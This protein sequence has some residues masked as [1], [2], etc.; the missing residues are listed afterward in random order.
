[1]SG[2]RLVRLLAEASRSAR[3]GGSAEDVL[4]ALAPAIEGALGAT[5]SLDEGRLSLR[6]G[7]AVLVLEAD[8]PP[9][10]S[11]AFDEDEI[12]AGAALAQ[13]LAAVGDREALFLQVLRSN[14]WLARLDDLSRGIVAR[15]DVAEIVEAT[16]D[17]LSELFGTDS[18]AV[19]TLVDGTP[20][21]AAQRGP[22]AEFA[23]H[24]VLCGADGRI[25]LGNPVEPKLPLGPSELADHHQFALVLPGSKGMDGVLVVQRPLGL[26][27]I[28]PDAQP[29][30][31]AIAGHLA[32]ALSN[33]RLVAEMRRLAAF[34]DLTGL[35]GR[36]HFATELDRELDRARRELRPLSM[37]MIDA[38]HF[39]AI[40]DVHGHAAGDAVLIAIAGTLKQC[41][42][43]L[44]VVGRLGGEELGV[45]LPGADAQIGL[46]VAERLRSAIERLRVPWRDEHI[47]VTVSVG[48]STWNAALS[49]AELL[50]RADRALYVAKASGRN[51]VVTW[52]TL[53]T[54]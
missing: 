31:S 33:A 38:D 37:L 3:D 36:R 28:D 15:T 24:V 2:S 19:Y 13:L 53:P 39:K 51:R 52:A 16:A 40:N 32:T 34:D 26:G 48:L 1:M 20:E 27:P 22:G 50:E 47:A 43:S 12:E 30:L 35:A 10:A 4:S 23:E 54:S 9:P 5:A 8:A 49:G 29:L 17:G 11:D 41:T 21:L 18:L 25:L 6:R 46:M 42:R 45:L 14:T 44:D 7:A